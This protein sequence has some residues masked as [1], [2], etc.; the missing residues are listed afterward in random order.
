MVNKSVIYKIISGLSFFSFLLM[1]LPCLADSAPTF[2]D[3]KK[4]PSLDQLYRSSGIVHKYADFSMFHYVPKGDDVKEQ[5]ERSRL[6]FRKKGGLP[7]G[8]AERK[9]DVIFYYNAAG[10]LVRIQKLSEDP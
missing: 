5:P 6:L 10:Q 7:D 2:G 4:K 3:I 1:S 8:Y 9:G